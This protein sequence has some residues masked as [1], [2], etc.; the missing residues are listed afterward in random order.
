MTKSKRI[1]YW[2]ATVW[3]AL[4]M[5]STAAVQLAHAAS[6]TEMMKH[7]GFPA[8]LLTIIGLA[9]V[10][11]VIAVLIPRT[12]ILKEWAYAGFFFLMTGAVWAHLEK[13]DTAKDLF[14]P[15]LLLVLSLS[16]W[17]LRPAS[18]KTA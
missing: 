5:A 3:L 15:L 9:K 12:P 10:L 8:Y 18:R 7:L 4:G 14:G 6:E 13:A 2:I 1:G 16:S 11:G 17:A